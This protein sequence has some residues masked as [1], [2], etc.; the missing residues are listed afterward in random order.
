MDESVYRGVSDAEAPVVLSD[1][2]QAHRSPSR[3]PGR[4]EVPI[5]IDLDVDRLPPPRRGRQIPDGPLPK[6][7]K[8]RNMEELQGIIQRCGIDGCWAQGGQQA[9]GRF[10][11]QNFVINI[12]KKCNSSST[13]WV[14]GERAGEIDARLKAARGASAPRPFALRLCRIAPPAWA[15]PKGTSRREAGPSLPQIGETQRPLHLPPISAGME[16]ATTQPQ[17]EH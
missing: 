5:V 13:V 11:G 6:S 3:S 16:V 4:L 15:S 1:D 14:Q 10:E 7:C 12:H 9:R 8:V 2:E 17:S